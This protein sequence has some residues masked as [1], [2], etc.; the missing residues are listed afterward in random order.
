[1]LDLWWVLGER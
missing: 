1:L